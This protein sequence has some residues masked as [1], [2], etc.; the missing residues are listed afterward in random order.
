MQHILVGKNEGRRSRQQI[1]AQLKAGADFAELAKKYSKDPGSKD[2]GGKFT[3]TKG[4]TSPSSTRSSSRRKTN[5]RARSRSTRAVRLAHHQAARRRQARQ[6]TTPEK[7]GGR[8]RSARSSLQQKKQHGDHEWVDERLKKLLHGRE[9]HVPGRLRSRRR[10]RARRSGARPARDH[11]AARVAGLAAR[12]CVEL[13]ELTERLRRDCPWDREQTAQTIVPHTVEEAYEVADAALAGDDAKLLDEL[14][15]LLFQAYFLALLLAE[16]GEGDLEPVARG[17]HAKLVARHPHVFGDV[18]AR[19]AGARAREL[20]AAQGRAGGARGR[21]PRRAG[22]AARR[23]SRAQGAA[24]RGGGRLRLPGRSPARSATSTTS[25][26]SC[27]RSCRGRAGGRARARPAA[28]RTSSATCSSPRVNV[29][30][31]LNVDPEL[32]LRARDASGSARGSR[33]PSALAAADGEDW[34]SSP[35]AEQDA[36]STGRRRASA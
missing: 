15:D 23:C 5:Q 19:P 28:S 1:Y 35:L 9:D 8:R 33:R 16:R 17:V 34:P 14:G 3:A 20:G 18:E 32:A 31:R 7:Q 22:D 13:Q 10:I 4:P 30:R 25:S 27:A 24:A 6:A 12:R 21:L 11:V 36:T 26:T 2:N 29:A